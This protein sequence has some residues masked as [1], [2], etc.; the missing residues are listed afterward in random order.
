MRE[1][2]GDKVA[3]LMPSLLALE[4]D[5]SLLLEW[6]QFPKFHNNGNVSLLH[7]FEEIGGGMR[8]G[9]EITIQ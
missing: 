5:M 8:S 6:Y 9:L 2:T 7:M 1:R 3:P 4:I